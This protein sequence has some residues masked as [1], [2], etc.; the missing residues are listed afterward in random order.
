MQCRYGGSCT[1]DCDLNLTRNVVDLTASRLEGGAV[2]HRFVESMVIEEEAA[3]REGCLLPFARTVATQWIDDV[4]ETEG[5]DAAIRLLSAELEK[6]LGVFDEPNR[7]LVRIVAA[8]RAAISEQ[9]DS[10]LRSRS[11]T[12]AA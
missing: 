1:R 5:E 12:G 8:D 11:F 10:W 9:I 2:R 3:L 7:V 4:E 6:E